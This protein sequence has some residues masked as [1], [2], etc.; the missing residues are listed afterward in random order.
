MIVLISVVN[1]NVTDLAVWWYDGRRPMFP[2]SPCLQ[3]V[4]AIPQPRDWRLRRQ[5]KYGN[6]A[7]QNV[8]NPTD[9]NQ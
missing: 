7:D 3:E 9:K 6:G 1:V 2:C 4:C 8:D 5:S